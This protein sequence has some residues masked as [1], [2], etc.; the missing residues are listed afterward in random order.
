MKLNYVD[1]YQW[2]F[3]IQDGVLIKLHPRWYDISS[4]YPYSMY[5]RNSK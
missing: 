1:V 3:T 5:G 2:V 4:M